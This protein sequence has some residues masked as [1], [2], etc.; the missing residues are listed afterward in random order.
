MTITARAGLAI[1]AAAAPLLLAGCA[2]DSPTAEPTASEPES[3]TVD[4]SEGPADCAARAWYGNVDS[5]FGREWL[6]SYKKNPST[7]GVTLTRCHY[8][9]HPSLE[10]ESASETALEAM[11]GDLVLPASI[12]AD[13]IEVRST[14]LALPDAPEVGHRCPGP[15]V[16][17]FDQVSVLD[18]RGTPV[19]KFQTSE[20]GSACGIFHVIPWA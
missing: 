5:L 6:L 12:I 13:G 2:P 15:G 8:L 17:A 11:T 14:L 1:L 16:A 7:S 4:A 10:L 19:A 18:D 20:H 9:H 3:T